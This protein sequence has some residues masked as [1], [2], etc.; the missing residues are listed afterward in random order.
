VPGFGLD[1]LLEGQLRRIVQA[2]LW[3]RH[4]GYPWRA[5]PL[6]LSGTPPGG[7]DPV[8]ARNGA[9]VSLSLTLSQAVPQTARPDRPGSG[10]RRRESA[11]ITP[12]GAVGA[13][14]AGRERAGPAEEPTT[15]AW[16]SSTPGATRSPRAPGSARHLA[17]RLV[18]DGEPAPAASGRA[19]RRNVDGAGQHSGGVS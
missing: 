9:P 10:S 1:V 11:N 5:A 6:V 14:P 4:G 2:R 17:P 13:M 3:A 12:P 15:L 18:L 7:L 16:R 19:C 8:T